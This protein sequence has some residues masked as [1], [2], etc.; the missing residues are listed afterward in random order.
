MLTAWAPQPWLIYVQ[1]QAAAG[2][3]ASGLAG[4]PL[5]DL[6]SV[7][8]LE[9]KWVW[10]VSGKPG[11]WTAVAPALVLVWAPAGESLARLT[12]ASGQKPAS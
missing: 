6:T 9:S 8:E 2:K 10:A 4:A 12:G 7:L 11:S 3:P 1:V 5:L